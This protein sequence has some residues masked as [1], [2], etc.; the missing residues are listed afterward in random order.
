MDKQTKHRYYFLALFALGLVLGATGI[1]CGCT[2]RRPVATATPT[3][4]VAAQIATATALPTA[5]RVPPTTAPTATDTTAPEPTQSP[6][7]P[8]ATK[9]QAISLTDP[10]LETLNDAVL[11]LATGGTFDLILTEA[12]VTNMALAYL[13]SAEELPLEISDVQVNFAPEQVK[14]SAKVPISIFSVEVVATGTWRAVDCQFEAEI[15]DVLI[16]GAAAPASIREQV[17]PLLQ[18]ALQASANLSACFTS[19]EISDDSL[20]ISGYKQ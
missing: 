6:T 7:Q 19:V 8:P 9:P 14:V 17:E 15:V 12:Y 16:A 11:G 3:R 2:A 4:I 13:D 10:S 18:N 20:T 1:G 5:T